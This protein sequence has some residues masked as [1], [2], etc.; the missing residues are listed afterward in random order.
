MHCVPVVLAT[1][2]SDGV[3]FVCL[4]KVRCRRVGEDWIQLARRVIEEMRGR[5]HCPRVHP[6]SSELLD[7]NRRRKP[8]FRALLPPM[9]TLTDN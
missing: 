2:S 7:Q 1:S 8:A 3:T 4:K 9:Y 5:Q 6:R